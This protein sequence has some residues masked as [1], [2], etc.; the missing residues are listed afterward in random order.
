MSFT[1][2]IKQHVI[3]QQP[4]ES[5][6]SRYSFK[7]LQ[8]PRTQHK[9]YDHHGQRATLRNGTFLM[10]CLPQTPSDTVVHLEL[11]MIPKVCADNLGG[12]ARCKKDVRS[13]FPRDLVKTRPNVNYVA[14]FFVCQVSWLAL[15][16]QTS[17][18]THPQLLCQRCLRRS[19]R[20]PTGQSTLG[21]S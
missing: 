1:Y 2:R 5:K 21:A 16:W 12:H 4:G 19:H 13:K 6:R 9:R 18:T 15:S 8:H 7:R 14:R 17:S 10:V 3:R 20:D 11:A